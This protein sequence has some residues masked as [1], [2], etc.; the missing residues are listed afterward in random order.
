MNDAKALDALLADLVIAN[1]ILAHEDVLD[2]FGHVAL[3]H[4]TRPD[5][6]F[7][8]RSR[9]P[10]LVTREDIL[11]FDLDANPIDPQG[12]R[13]YLESILHARIFAA[14]PDVQASVH[15]HAPAVL[16]FTVSAIPLKPI[17]HMGSVLGGEVPIWDS[18]TEFGDTNM[19]VDDTP[20]AD[21]LAR[22][23]GD[24]PAALLWNHGAVCVAHSLPAV[25]F[26][27]IRMKDN[28]KLQQAAL[29]FG[30]PRYL[31]E[32]EIAMT[33][34]TL[35]GDRPLERAWAYFRARAGF[36]GL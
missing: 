19:L 34:A 16:P 25:V 8:S 6:F 14:R 12:R 3:R 28:A 29:A 33:R 30:A 35:L 17:F 15:H 24:R 21:S 20:K 23:R 5:R 22:A 10:E 36:A 31:T 1:R 9:S 26:V 2:D 4:P 32:G 11:E 27:S 7:L 18:R 13:P